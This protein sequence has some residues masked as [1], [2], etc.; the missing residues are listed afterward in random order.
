M[1]EYGKIKTSFLNPEDYGFDKASYSDIAEGKTV[2]ENADI[3]INILNQTEKGPK[4]DIVLLNSGALIYLSGL[5]KTINEG[6]E[7]AKI[8]IESENALNTLNNFIKIYK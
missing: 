3:F 1:K 7:L 6:I 8:S 5:A 4:R 2:N